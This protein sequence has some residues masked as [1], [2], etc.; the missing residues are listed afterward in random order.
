MRNSLGFLISIFASMKLLLF[1]LTSA[2][3]MGASLADAAPLAP[4]VSGGLWHKMPIRSSEQKAAGI[5]GGEGTQWPR[6]DIAVSPADPNFL[7]LP[8]DVGG[9]Y[10]SHDGGQTWN[11]AMNGWNARGANAF[12]IDPKN[13]RRVIGVAG[14][15]MNWGE[16]WGQSPHGLYLSTDG[17]ASWTQTA[18][19]LD[20]YSCSVAFDPTSSDAAKGF[21]TRAYYLSQDGN[22]FRSDDGGQTWQA[23][24]QGP[25]TTGLS[26]DWTQGGSFIAL[27]RVNPK[28]GDVWVSGANGVYCS[29]DHGESFENKRSNASFGMDLSSDG[30]VFSSDAGGVWRSGDD[31]ATWTSTGNAGLDLQGQFA[32]NVHVSP[33]DAKRLLVWVPGQN[34]NWKRFVSLDGGANWMESKLDK[35]GATLPTNARQGYFAWHP[36][37]PNIAWSLGG[38]WVSKSTDGGRNFGWSNSGYNGVMLGSSMNF[39]A[40]APDTVFLG[41]QDYNGAFTTDGGQTW[42][43]RDVSGLGWGGQIYGAGQSGTALMWCG[44]SEG[45]SSPRRLK[46]SRDGGKTW[47]FVNGAD[48][49]PLVWSGAEVS[50]TSPKNASI[51]FASNFRTNDLGATWT[52]MSGCDGVFISKPDGTLIGR[53]G[54]DIVTSSDDGESW[55]KVVTVDGGIRDIAFDSKR[56]RYFVSS[57]DVLKMWDGTK[58]TTID[59]P[60]DQYGNRRVQTVAID[61]GNPDIMY[62]GGARDTYAT[63]TTCVRS[64]DG[65]ASWQNLTRGDGAH[66]VSWIRVNPRTHQAWAAGQCYGMW[67]LDPP[68]PGE[69]GANIPNGDAPRALPVSLLKQLDAVKIEAAR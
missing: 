34:W 52:P 69:L 1:V 67:R 21:C 20:A 14:N 62:A 26:R 37:N 19:R 25:I 53:K 66:E 36:T 40:L 63:S 4:A 68:K 16:G 6:G 61:P 24:S 59:T 22:L 13:A 31:G 35:N 7:L 64:L 54:D 41:F 28:S 17:A 48:G 11:I 44:D 23:A 30:T 42:N 27:V 29:K 49:K 39:S 45:W 5:I 65:G 50:F 18:A 55:T 57:Q 43:Y 32:A 60:R 56:N 51:C 12:A 10:A 3:I 33:A 8:I 9:L 38:D 15:S 46:Q 58:W 2:G 47:A